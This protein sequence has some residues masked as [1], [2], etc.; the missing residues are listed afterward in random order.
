MSIIA[1]RMVLLFAWMAKP[2]SRRCDTDASWRD[3]SPGREGEVRA[4]DVGQLDPLEV[5]PNASSGFCQGHRRAL[6]LGA[7]PLMA[8][9]EKFIRSLSR[10]VCQPNSAPLAFYTVTGHPAGYAILW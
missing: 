7:K 8:L 4:V 2:G 10:S 5:I 3:A 1:P 9:R 6:A